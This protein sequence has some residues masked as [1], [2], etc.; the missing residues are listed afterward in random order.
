MIPTRILTLTSG[1]QVSLDYSFGKNLVSFAMQLPA[2]GSYHLQLAQKCVRG[3]YLSSKID[4]AFFIELSL[5]KPVVLNCSSFTRASVFVNKLA[6]SSSPVLWLSSMPC[7]RSMPTQDARRAKWQFSTKS[8]GTEPWLESQR[9][10]IVAF[11][12]QGRDLP[13]L[14][15]KIAILSISAIASAIAPVSACK[16]SGPSRFVA[17]TETSE[18]YLPIG[19]HARSDLDPIPNKA[20]I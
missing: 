15:E 5:L 6:D 3:T 12:L 8:L 16:S 13:N 1:S 4:F 17:P 14:P 11:S 9:R 20:L 2:F 18:R 10:G 19:S 7:S